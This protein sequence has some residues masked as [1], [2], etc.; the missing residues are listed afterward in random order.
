VEIH[1]SPAETEKLAELLRRL[2]GVDLILARIPDQTNRIL[3]MNPGGEK[4]F[5]DWNP[6]TDSYRYTSATGDPIQYLPVVDALRNKNQLDA[7]GF[8]ISENWMTATMTHRYPLAPE[9]IVHGLTRITLNPATILVSLK[10]GY[11]NA[12]WM[13]KKSSELLTQGG[14]H[15]GL[16]DINSDGIL[17]SN[18]TPTKDTS[19]SRVAG[20]F[21]DFPGLQNYRTGENGAAW[22]SGKEQALVRIAREPFDSECK[23]LPGEGIFLRIWSPQFEHLDWTTSIEITVEAVPRFL[24][25]RIRRWDPRSDETSEKH[26]SLTLP[27][28]FAVKCAYERVYALPSALILEP[29]KGYRISGRAYDLKDRIFD[30]T[31]HTDNHG[32]PIA[33]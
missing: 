19:A 3:A 16:D 5:I 13:V 29:G 7:N 21:D 28:S 1:N 14:T 8:A 10:N 2:E 4:A 12:N 30:F 15:G 11:V 6:A 22:V 33:Y 24:V 31:F 27:I 23:S 32:M 26:L 9:R 25:A 17:L 18:F 20:L